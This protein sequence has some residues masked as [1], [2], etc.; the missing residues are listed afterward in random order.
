MADPL[1]RDAMRLIQ[2]IVMEAKGSLADP[3]SDREIEA[4]LR[5]CARLSGTDW[6][7][8]R[9]I[10]DVWRLDTLADVSGRMR[11]HG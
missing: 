8:D 1:L 10:D 9:V 2:D 3:L 5:D 6:N 4:K 7:T 11:A